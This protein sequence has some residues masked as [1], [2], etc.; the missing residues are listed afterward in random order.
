M[1]LCEDLSTTG[2]ESKSIRHAFLS[3]FG[4]HESALSIMC[5]WTA[6]LRVNRIARILEESGRRALSEL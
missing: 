5:Q 4:T 2:E 3:H 6:S 1:H